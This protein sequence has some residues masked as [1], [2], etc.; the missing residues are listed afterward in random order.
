[1]RDLL[2][3]LLELPA[4]RDLPNENRELVR[5]L[6]RLHLG[7]GGVGP[8]GQLVTFGEARPEALPAPVPWATV[9]G[10]TDKAGLDERL[11][12]H[13]PVV[14]L[15]D[16]G[17]R[18]APALGRLVLACT[19]RVSLGPNSM[20]T[21]AEWRL[22]IPGGRTETLWREQDCQRRFGYVVLRTLRGLISRIPP[23]RA[24]P[25]PN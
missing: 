12:R 23:V 17:A 9:V 15:A 18:D 3:R 16:D 10:R 24:E 5:H 14:L 13:K 20:T 19:G 11:P 4:Y 8:A 25:Q 21:A 2:Y 1:M 6:D 22:H 7:L